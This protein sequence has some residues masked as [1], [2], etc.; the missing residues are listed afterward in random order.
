MSAGN[1]GMTSLGRP[2][3]SDG[4][5]IM[6][7]SLSGSGGNPVFLRGIQL[8]HCSFVQMKSDGRVPIIC[9]FYDMMCRR[10]ATVVSVACK[11]TQES[12]SVAFWCLDLYDVWTHHVD[13][14]SPIHAGVPF[15]FSEANKEGY[16]YWFPQAAQGKMT[17][18][19]SV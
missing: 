15:D 11:Q 6:A 16:G 10:Y 1:N 14:F 5:K 19:A 3:S 7:E 12:C 13:H 17:D 18:Q 4:S 8:W 2:R 9:V